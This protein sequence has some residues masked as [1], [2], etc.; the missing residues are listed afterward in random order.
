MNKITAFIF[1]PSRQ[2]NG[3]KVLSSFYVLRWRMDSKN[4]GKDIPLNVRDHQVAEKMKADFIRQ[5]EREL[6]GIAEPK[7]LLD[8]AQKP[9]VEHLA[10]FIKD[11]ISRNKDEMYVYTLEKRLLKLCKE[12]NWRL[13]KD[14][15]PDSFALW[16]GKQTLSAKTK[17]DYLA[18]CSNF[19]NWLQRH[20]R[21]INNSL[22]VVGKV[23]T[24]GKERRKRRALTDD[25]IRRL[26]EMSDS[27]RVVYLTAVNTG[28]RRAEM[29]QMQKCDVDLYRADPLIRARSSTTKNHKEGILW[30]NEELTNELKKL[31]GPDDKGVDPV[32]ERVPSIEEY[33]EDLEAAGIPY[34]DEQGRVAD[35]HALRHT[36]GTNLARAGVPPRIAMAIMRHSD[37][38]LTNTTYTDVSQLPIAEAVNKLPTFG[39]VKTNAPGNAP[40]LVKPC[41]DVSSPV[42]LVNPVNGEKPLATI[43][44]CPALSLVVAGSQKAGVVP[45]L[46][47]EPRTN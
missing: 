46:G 7:A 41:L 38:R 36:L 22:K 9:L 11:Q 47:L 18:D 20:G 15:T 34:K 37:M 10:D 39:T 16:R 5:K 14:V 44:D 17:N 23:E 6:N 43:G 3:R 40:N 12:C 2:K 35:F 25:E 33:R 19:L 27:R 29:E 8:A 21:I 13:A 42:H 24:R 31:V 30:L 4:G 1:R 32:F 28:L 26:F 45:R